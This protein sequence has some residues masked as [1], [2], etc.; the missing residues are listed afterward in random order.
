MKKFLYY[1]SNGD[2][3]VPVCDNCGTKIW[4][5]SNICSN[6]FSK[7]IGMSKLESKGRL[8]EYSQSFIGESKNLGLV[9][10]SGIRLIGS[11]SQ[12][13]I[14]PGSPVKLTRCGLDRDNFPYYEFSST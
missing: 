5:P 9:E 14:S 2:F 3:R 11:L 7:K 13:N 12:A 8:I 10:I 1:L 6:C 4:P